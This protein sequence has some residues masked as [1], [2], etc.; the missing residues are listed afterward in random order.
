RRR[1]AAG[2]ARSGRRDGKRRG[3]RL[4]V[5]GDD[6]AGPA[7]SRGKTASG[8]RRNGDRRDSGFGDL[9]SQTAR[10]K[11]RRDGRRELNRPDRAGRP[12]GQKGPQQAGALAR[13]DVES[14]S[15]AVSAKAL[16]ITWHF[17]FPV[18]DRV[19]AKNTAGTGGPAVESLTC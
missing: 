4:D 2:I 11:R 19:C 9:Q 13:Y 7:H 10:R 16:P 8:R 1:P 17:Y 6:P 15:F 5:G 14:L 12:P 3:R 18:D